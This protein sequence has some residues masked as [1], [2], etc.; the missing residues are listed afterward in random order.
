MKSILIADDSQIVLLVMRKKLA[1]LDGQLSI[2]TQCSGAAALEAW[3][4]SR[5]DLTILDV[6]M[7][8]LD[9]L[10]VLSAIQA[11]EPGAPVLMVS[12]CRS[13]DIEQRCLDLGARAFLLK[14]HSDL[15]GAVRDLL[16]IGGREVA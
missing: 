10:E 9:G 7:P 2:E 3:R 13:S 6:V 14:D 4:R 1:A 12:S 8:D 15:E 11:E 5:P 16:G